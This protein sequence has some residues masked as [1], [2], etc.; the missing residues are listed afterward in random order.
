M[1]G[2]VSVPS[3]ENGYA[4][5]TNLKVLGS[6]FSY[7]YILFTCE[8]AAFTLWYYPKPGFVEETGYPFYVKPI[9]L[10]TNVSKISITKNIPKSIKEGVKFGSELSPIV[11]IM[12]SQGQYLAEKLVFINIH[13]FDGKKYPYRYVFERKGFKS[14]QILNPISGVYNDESNNPLSSNDPIVPLLTNAK[15]IAFFNESYFSKYGAV[16]IYE[17]EFICDGVSTVSSS[18]NVFSC[19]LQFF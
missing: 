8:N 13:S 2:D 4:K 14:K 19:F 12:D 17:I 3:D 15:G 1:Q 16:G 7:T 11:Q 9:K 5:F 18:I 10:V 6:T